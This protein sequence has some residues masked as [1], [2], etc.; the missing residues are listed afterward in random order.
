MEGGISDGSISLR[1]CVSA[2][3]PSMSQGTGMTR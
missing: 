3:N 1:L 2:V